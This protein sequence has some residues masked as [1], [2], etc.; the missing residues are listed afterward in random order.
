LTLFGSKPVDAMVKE[1][2]NDLISMNFNYWYQKE[3][4]NQEL[5]GIR[6]YHV[7]NGH[8]KR[9]VMANVRCQ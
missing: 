7:F 1:V 5:M 2:E 4:E 8:G 3:V 6:G 9:T